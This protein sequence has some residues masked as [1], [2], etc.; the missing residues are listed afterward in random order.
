MPEL[1]IGDVATWLATVVAIVSAIAATRPSKSAD[2]Y[3]GEA[4]QHAQVSAELLEKRTSAE[5]KPALTK[6]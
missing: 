5:A 2:R 1:Q 6:R 4:A 3:Q